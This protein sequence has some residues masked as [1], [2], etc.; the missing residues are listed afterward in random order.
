MKLIYNT[1]TNI[2]YLEK[3]FS[4]RI[5]IRDF[6]INVVKND[7]LICF[8]SDY[9]DYD[10]AIQLENKCLEKECNFLPIMFDNPY[11][12]IGPK[13]YVNEKDACLECSYQRRLQ[14]MGDA[15]M[16]K[17]V[18]AKKTDKLFVNPLELYQQNIIL[19][20][21]K[22]ILN[23]GRKVEGKVLV[24]NMLTMESY[25]SS[26]VGVHNCSK[27][28]LKRNASEISYIN[29]QKYFGE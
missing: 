3:L 4:E 19:N 15:D 22:S 18:L 26:I 23:N 20:I 11:V 6:D 9:V 16:F 12:M 21:L 2:K 7:K 8:I 24:L 28:G 13:N 25:T 10:S 29:I 14:H 17:E 27:C 5:Q 1:N